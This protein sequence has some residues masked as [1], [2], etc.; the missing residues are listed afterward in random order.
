MEVVEDTKEEVKL[1]T[2]YGFNKC[3]ETGVDVFAPSIFLYGCNLRCPYCMNEV[4]VT[5]TPQREVNLQEV[6][7]FVEHDKSEWLM[8]SGGEPTLTQKDLLINLLEEIKSWGVRIGM[9]TN[10]SRPDVIEDFIHLMD[11]FALDIKAP[12]K[13]VYE[14][15]SVGKIESF[16]NLQ[17]TREL[18]EA[19]REKREE[20]DFEV[21]TTLFPKYVNRET[22][23]EIGDTIKQGDIWVL[24]QFRHAKNMIDDSVRDIPPYDK[25]EL[26]VLLEIAKEYT[27]KVHIRDV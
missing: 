1:P 6:R 26:Q 21:R 23:R 17:K 19:E 9:S 3:S 18:F 25:E 16:E 14:S 15:I 5:G 24:Q 4:V 12:N 22:L 2:V 27:D 7:D 8:I 13:K 10:G 20:F 11:Y